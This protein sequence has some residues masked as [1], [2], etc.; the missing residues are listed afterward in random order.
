MVHTNAL[1]SKLSFSAHV[2]LQN[3]AVS[4]SDLKKGLRTGKLLY[5]FQLYQ[6][7]LE[8]KDTARLGHPEDEAHA[9]LPVP[10][11]SLTPRRPT[12][13]NW[14]DHRITAFG[15]AQAA[16]T[17][18]YPQLNQQLTQ[19]GELDRPKAITRPLLAFPLVRR[20]PNWGDLASLPVSPGM[21]DVPGQG[22]GAGQACA[23]LAGRQLLANLS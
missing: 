13:A 4:A 20:A 15:S 21:V 18:G 10:R 22:R 6:E 8:G 3:H 1:N 14:K 16:T 23:V 2:C 11:E 12:A 19:P 17:R 9:T 5:F 7:E